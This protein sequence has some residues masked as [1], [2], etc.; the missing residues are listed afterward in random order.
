MS[1]K[2]LREHA[3]LHGHV[4]AGAFPERVI[5]PH[6]FVADTEAFV[7]VR[8]PRSKGKASYSF[9]GPGVSQNDDQFINLTVPHG[10]N[11]G[12]ATLPHG[13]INNPHLHFTAEVFI[14]TR[15][16]FRFDIGEHGGQSIDVNAGT[17]FSVPT[18]VFRAFENTGVDDGWLFAVLGGDDT[19]GIIWAP[20]ILSE[21]AETGMYLGQDYS[22]LDET[23]GDD[24]SDAIQPLTA[25][26]L[27]GRVARYTDAE[28]GGRAVSP[29]DLD[30]SRKALLSSVVPGHETAVAPV[31]G[32][33]LSQDRTHK[34]PITNP[35]SFSLEW[36]EVA[37]GAS[38]GLHRHGHSQA[39][40]LIDGQWQIE[41]EV[42][43]DLEITSPAEGSIVS[44]PENAWRNLKNLGSAPAHA[45]VVCGSDAP[46][47]V[48]WVP[49]IVEA[50]RGAGWAVDASGYLAPAELLG[51]RP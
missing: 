13:V 22:L 33:G 45:V 17:V 6:D 26:A 39:T 16:S 34:S 14:C 3:A 32:H 21:A 38:T 42:D 11:V 19:G 50:A 35:H 47:R 2:P 51:G 44:V 48:E 41:C 46:T 15:G 43:G 25:E 1:H 20:H 5:E 36:L 27:A 4:D 18:W 7:D 31:I 29:D 10:F 30:W 40:F 37:P 24:V 28:L 9:I 8:I 12:A 49:E 23:A